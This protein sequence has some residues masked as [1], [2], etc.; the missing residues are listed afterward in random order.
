MGIRAPEVFFS[1]TSSFPPEGGLPQHLSRSR[2]AFFFSLGP[3]NRFAPLGISLRGSIFFLGPSFPYNVP[4]RG[5]AE[6]V[7]AILHPIRS[8]LPPTGS[9]KHPAPTVFPLPCTPSNPPHKPYGTTRRV[10]APNA[11]RLSRGPLITCR[12]RSRSSED[13]RNG[14]QGTGPRVALLKAGSLFL[15]S[16]QPFFTQQGFWKMNCHRGHHFFKK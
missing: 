14:S 7:N 5:R 12:W 1:L 8:F 15:D 3:P 9:D 16:K 4:H 6:K 2:P 13:G 10:P 11:R